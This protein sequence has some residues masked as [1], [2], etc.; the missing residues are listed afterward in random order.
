MW[1][2]PRANPATEEMQQRAGGASRARFFM[3]PAANRNYERARLYLQGY[4]TGLRGGCTIAKAGD[5]AAEEIGND[6]LQTIS[7]LWSCSIVA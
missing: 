6:L 3:L 2:A 4:E 7:W 5:G 1:S